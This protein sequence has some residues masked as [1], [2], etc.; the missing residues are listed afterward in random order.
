MNEV[1]ESA[2]N[3]FLEEFPGY[4]TINLKPTEDIQVKLVVL[5]VLW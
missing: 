3:I 5:G 1:R 4:I 2:E